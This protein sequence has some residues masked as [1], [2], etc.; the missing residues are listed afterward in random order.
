MRQ[1][2]YTEHHVY[3]P[4]GFFNSDTPPKHLYNEMYTADWW[5]ETQV[6]R[7]TPG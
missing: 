6:G 3:A 2:A 4:L 1:P 5:W 7:D